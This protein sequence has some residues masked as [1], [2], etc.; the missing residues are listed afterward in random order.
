MNSLPNKNAK[1]AGFSLLEV[2]I[3]V[4][5]LSVGILGMAGLQL[6]S[7]K[8]NQTA[9]IR[10]QATVLSYDIADRMRANRAIANTGGYNL[11]ITEEPTGTSISSIDLQQWRSALSQYLPEGKGSVAAA[12]DN[13]LIT[14]TWDEGRLGE[15][16]AQK[17]VFETRL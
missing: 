14:V 17:F 3:A 4:L 2:L 6:N 8:F 5:V 16:D 10:S 13:V 11:A 1:Q 7:M 9:T 15:A 12:G